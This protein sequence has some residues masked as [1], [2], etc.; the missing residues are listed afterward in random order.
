MCSERHSLCALDKLWRHPSLTNYGVISFC[1][2]SLKSKYYDFLGWRLIGIKRFSRADSSTKLAAKRCAGSTLGRGCVKT[3]SGVF[4]CAVLDQNRQRRCGSDQL[5]VSKP[6]GFRVGGTLSMI[7]LRFHT[8]Q[9]GSEADRLLAPSFLQ[10]SWAR[11]LMIHGSH[12]GFFTGIE[13]RWLIT[14]IRSSKPTTSFPKLT[15]RPFEN[16]MVAT[17]PALVIRTSMEVALEIA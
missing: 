8:V 11:V 12:T 13:E 4:H 9:S 15:L 6:M 1:K 17:L 3:Q 14:E 2:Y 16:E 10:D 5:A 7:N